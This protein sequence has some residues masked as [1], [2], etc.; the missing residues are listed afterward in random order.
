MLPTRMSLNMERG[1]QPPTYNIGKWKTLVKQA[2]EDRELM[3]HICRNYPSQ[4]TS[5]NKNDIATCMCGQ[6]L[7]RHDMK[8]KSQVQH[9]EELEQEHNVFVQMAPN[10]C[11]ILPGNIRV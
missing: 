10:D 6:P 7:N 3:S 9:A 8:D 1:L 4:V 2:G 5:A 11:G